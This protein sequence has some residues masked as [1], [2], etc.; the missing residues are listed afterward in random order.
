MTV[1]GAGSPDSPRPPSPPLRPPPPAP[2]HAPS[3][4][5]PASSPPFSSLTHASSCSSLLSSLSDLIFLLSFNSFSFLSVS[6]PLLL[7]FSFSPRP[8]SPRAFTK[9]WTPQPE[10]AQSFCPS[11]RPSPA[12]PPCLP[13]REP[14][15]TP[16]G[17]GRGGPAGNRHPEAQ[18]GALSFSPARWPRG[19][20][21]RAPPGAPRHAG[22]GGE[23]QVGVRERAEFWG[24]IF[25][26]AFF[27]AIY[28]FASLPSAPASL[29]PRCAPH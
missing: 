19:P 12:G 23:S 8:H 9:T 13:R 7:L 25:W 11:V 24:R 4:L 20:G 22:K 17:P 10:G 1:R 28:N 15:P 29:A 16:W 6:S 2:P 5:P 18:A 3:F 14:A 26:L 27:M 21:A